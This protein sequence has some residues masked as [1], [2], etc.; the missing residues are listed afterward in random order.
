MIHSPGILSQVQGW[1]CGWKLSSSPVAAGLSSPDSDPESRAG[2]LC[3]EGPWELYLRGHSVPGPELLPHPYGCCTDWTHEEGCLSPPCPSQPVPWSQ[4]RQSLAQCSSS[5]R[6]SF[7]F[8]NTDLSRTLIVSN[9]HDW[10]VEF[11][12]VVMKNCKNRQ[13]WWSHDIVNVISAT[14][15]YT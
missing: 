14:E 10:A 1:E 12:F 7:W 4:S 9:T 15:L 3:S 8:L 2:C 11:L 13:W 5:L 6:S